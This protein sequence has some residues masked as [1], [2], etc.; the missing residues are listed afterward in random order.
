MNDLSGKEDTFNAHKTA[1]SLATFRIYA[2]M[3][4]PRRQAPVSAAL[5]MT[6]LVLANLCR[7]K[8]T[9]GSAH[10]GDAVG[11]CFPDGGGWAGPVGGQAATSPAML[12]QTKRLSWVETSCRPAGESRPLQKPHRREPSPEQLCRGLEAA[13][14]P[15]E[16][17][18]QPGARRQREAHGPVPGLEARLWR[19]SSFH[20]FAGCVELELLLCAAPGKAPPY[21]VTTT[22]DRGQQLPTPLF[23]FHKENKKGSRPQTTARSPLPCGL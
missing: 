18:C 22:T 16:L 23:F 14:E 12:L 19:T 1:H 7:R 2:C 3:I 5:D 13:M 4:T 11:H 10:S 9:V 8:G 17:S 20:H 15:G 6:R 21:A